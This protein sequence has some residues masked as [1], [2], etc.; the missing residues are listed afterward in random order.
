M[1]VLEALYIP[2]DLHF[3]VNRIRQFLPMYE[4]VLAHTYFCLHRHH[5][6]HRLKARA[7]PSCFGT[8]PL[9]RIAL[10]TVHSV[11]F[12]THVEPVKLAISQMQFDFA[13]QFPIR[14]S[15]QPPA[16]FS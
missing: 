7:G 13:F 15:A 1:G 10:P 6:P 11:L 14:N 12:F 8:T 5:H 4:Y 16:C 3:P 2:T 9:E